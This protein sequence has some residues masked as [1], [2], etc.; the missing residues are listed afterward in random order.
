MIAA[1][2]CT[3]AVNGACSALGRMWLDDGVSLESP[4]G[5]IVFAVDATSL[6]VRAQDVLGLCGTATLSTTINAIT[7]YGIPGDVHPNMQISINN[8]T[9]PDAEITFEKEL[10]RLRIES[11]QIDWCKNQGNVVVQ[12]EIFG[13]D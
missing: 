3:E 9:A 4:S 5:E 10:R 7:I 12:W 1:L 11:L 8:A 2:E 13:P 6:T